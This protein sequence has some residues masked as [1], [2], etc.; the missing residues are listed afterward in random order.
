[1]FRSRSNAANLEHEK[2]ALERERIALYREKILL[3]RA[4]LERD[5]P[6]H[7]FTDHYGDKQKKQL[8]PVKQPPPQYFKYSAQPPTTPKV[9]PRPAPPPPVRIPE[10][11]VAEP[12]DTPPKA[13]F[14]LRGR[15]ASHS[16]FQNSFRR[17]PAVSMSS[18]ASS[19][20]FRSA[21]E[22]EGGDEASQKRLHVSTLEAAEEEKQPEEVEQVAAVP[23]IVAPFEQEEEMKTVTIVLQVPKSATRVKVRFCVA[24]DEFLSTA[25]SSERQAKGRRIVEML[26]SDLGPF[27]C[28]GIAPQVQDRLE[29]LLKQREPI[30][31]VK[32]AI[33]KVL[34]NALSLPGKQQGG[35]V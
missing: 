29:T 13:S 35:K 32:Q 31:E 20:S 11:M 1:M 5:T 15:S 24:L 16:S 12:E 33:V 26:V 18:A 17:L 9:L 30:P 2:I 7:R 21:Q 4:R 27:K 28:C 8:S 14:R 6:N 22:E 25:D 19:S 3:E 34:S 23:T 10:A